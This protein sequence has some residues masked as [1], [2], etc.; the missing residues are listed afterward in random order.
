MFIYNVIS[1]KMRLSDQTDASLLNVKSLNNEF[2]S[3]PIHISLYGIPTHL[4]SLETMI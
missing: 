3:A 4:D 1:D 2:Q